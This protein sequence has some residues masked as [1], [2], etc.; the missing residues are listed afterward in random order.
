MACGAFQSHTN[1]KYVAHY[2]F[3]SHMS[4][5]DQKKEPAKPIKKL[6]IVFIW[7]IPTMPFRGW[8]IRGVILTSLVVFRAFVRRGAVTN[9]F[10]ASSL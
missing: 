7:F 8:T 1:G 6:G 3:K 4:Q 9:S 5:G 10:D 2:Y